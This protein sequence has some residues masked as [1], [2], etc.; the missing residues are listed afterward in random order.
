MEPE[1]IEDIENLKTTNFKVTKIRVGTLKE[2]KQFCKE[3]CGNIYS[4][5]I[6]RLLEIKK[7]YETL[8]PLISS[9]QRDLSLIKN[10]SNK[11]EVKTFA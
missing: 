3:K 9:I 4:L 7:E 5:G 11:K 8:I 1:F 10:Q 2:F 6:Q